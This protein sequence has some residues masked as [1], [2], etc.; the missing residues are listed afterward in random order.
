MTWTLRAIEDADG[1]WSCRREWS[2]EETHANVSQVITHLLDVAHALGS[3][4]LLVESSDGHVKRLGREG[5]GD[6]MATDSDSEG[7]ANAN[8][9]ANATTATQC[10]I[11]SVMSRLRSART[12][13]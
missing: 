8:A 5:A 3:A 9:N 6:G 1:R 4:N 13:K 2:E 10:R 11:D 12:T 7:R